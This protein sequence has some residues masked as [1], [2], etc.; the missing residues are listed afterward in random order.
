MKLS[1]VLDKARSRRL[2]ALSLIEDGDLTYKQAAK[3]MGVSVARFSQL[4]AKARKE[5][6]A[7]RE[8]QGELKVLADL[9]GMRLAEEAASEDQR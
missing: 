3:S 6:R 1:I 8:E 2:H 9:E 5:L 7:M 4:V